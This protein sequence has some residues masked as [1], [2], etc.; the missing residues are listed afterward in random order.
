[1]NHDDLVEIGRRSIRAAYGERESVLLEQHSTQVLL[2]AVADMLLA[3]LRPAPPRGPSE[4]PAA[5]EW[6]A[7]PGETRLVALDDAPD[8]G[9]G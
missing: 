7:G 6:P 9:K 5:S 2:G 3:A 8:E 1:V 4:W